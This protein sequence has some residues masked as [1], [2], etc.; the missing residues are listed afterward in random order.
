MEPD[1]S[2]LTERLT[3]L[4]QDLASQTEK[5]GGSVKALKLTERSEPI[6]EKVEGLVA[7]H[8]QLSDQIGLKIASLKEEDIPYFEEISRTA[9]DFHRRVENFGLALDKIDAWEKDLEGLIGIGPEGTTFNFLVTQY[10][11]QINCL[12]I[13][14]TKFGEKVNACGCCMDIEK[15][16]TLIK[17]YEDVLTNWANLLKSVED[18]LKSKTDLFYN[19]AKNREDLLKSYEDLVKSA[20]E[21]E[22]KRLDLLN[23][24]M[25][26]SIEF[27][28][29][30]EALAKSQAELAN[31]LIVNQALPAKNT[32]DLLKSYEDLL[33]SV[34][35][36]I[37]SIM[38]I[39]AGK[40]LF[41][42]MPE[43]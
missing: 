7:Q 25:R 14:V 31:S 36:L 27:A 21:V 40:K 33:K 43:K 18:L 30:F 20:I 11:G 6:H 9:K 41:Q 26:K 15:N 24:P 1:I 28:T 2:A 42:A 19:L 38:E 13:I 12:G 10:M 17:S 39:F 37:K 16:E 5:F 4:T 22:D 3:K 29:S 32:E 34:E 8:A 23:K 35:D